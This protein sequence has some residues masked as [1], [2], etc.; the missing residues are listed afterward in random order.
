MTVINIFL[1]Y[2]ET[3]IHCTCRQGYKG[4]G[5]GINGCVIDNNTFID[6]CANKPCGPHGMCIK[7]ANNSFS[8]FC[9][10]GYTGNQTFVS[11]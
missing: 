11:I 9:K 3:T 4:S 1:V 5:F 6:P 8:C 2:A 7:E 10:R